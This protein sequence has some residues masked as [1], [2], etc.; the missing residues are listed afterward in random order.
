MLQTAYTLG[1]E[2]TLLSGQFKKLLKVQCKNGVRLFEDER[3]LYLF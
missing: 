1:L 3:Y 2:P